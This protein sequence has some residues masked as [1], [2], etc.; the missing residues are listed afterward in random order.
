MPN[1]MQIDDVK[2]EWMQMDESMAS[3]TPHGMVEHHNL[4]NTVMQDIQESELNYCLES[5]IYPDQDMDFPM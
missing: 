1:D 2:E 3:S 4:E 5:Q